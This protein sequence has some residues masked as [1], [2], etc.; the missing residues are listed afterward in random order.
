MSKKHKNNR[1]SI[2][3]HSG[4]VPNSAVPGHFA[5]EYAFIKQD[6]VRLLMLN[7]LYL[8]LLLALY[9]YDLSHNV[10]HKYLDKFIHL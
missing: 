1:V 8:G 2:N 4:M 6:L 3:E 7:V 10:L 5:E 9:Y